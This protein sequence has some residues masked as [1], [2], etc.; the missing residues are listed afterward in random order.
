MKY[1]RKLYDWVLSWAKTTYGP[2]ILFLIAF[3]ESSFFPVPPD[4]LLIALSLGALSKSFRFAFIT[5]LGSVLGGMFGYFIG[6]QLFNLIGEPILKFYGLMAKYYEVQ[7]LYNLYNAWIVG[8]AGFTPIPFKLAT[9][10]AGVCKVDF[11]IFILASAFSR[12]ARFFL[13]AV[14]FKIFG[15]KIKEFID[16]Y[17][18]LLSIL[19]FLLLLGGFII[20]KKIL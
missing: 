6:F 8:I 4:I 15:E 10:T 9:I 5:A 13:I 17:F 14:L 11:K 2:L 7:N 19:F 20:I 16:K 12:S 18:N 3:A 1:L